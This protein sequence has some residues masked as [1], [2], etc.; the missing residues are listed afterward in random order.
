MKITLKVFALIAAL[1]SAVS[2]VSCSKSKAQ[3]LKEVRFATN[4]FVGNAPFYV[5]FEKGYF[6][7]EGIDFKLQNYE[8]STSACTALITGNAEIAYT[9]LDAALITE[10]QTAENKLKVFQIVCNKQVFVYGVCNSGCKSHNKD[11]CAGH[12]YCR[13]KFF[14]NTKERADAEEFTENK[15]FCK[16]C[17]KEN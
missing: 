5:A 9:T 15:V 4:P 6:A 16:N 3:N 2:F 10:S 11:N 17:C 7:Q 13:V 1:C 14:G 8:K 12:T